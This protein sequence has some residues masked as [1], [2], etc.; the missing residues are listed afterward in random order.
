MLPL[1]LALSTQLGHAGQ[2]SCSW[3][4][5]LSLPPSALPMLLFTHTDIKAG[6]GMF[7]SP[8]TDSYWAVNCDSNNYGVFNKTS[9]LSAFPCKP[10]PAGMQARTDLTASLKY[11]ATDGSGRQGFTHPLAC[12]T[13]KGHGYNGRVGVKCA[14]G[15]YNEEGNYDE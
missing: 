2:P 7:Y 13:Q 5:T 12:V 9:G 8:V 3:L 4:I 6:Q 15:S 11:W 1:S 14:V 10:C